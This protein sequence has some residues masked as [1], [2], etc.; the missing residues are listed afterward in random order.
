MRGGD[1]NS[2]NRRTLTVTL[3]LTV[4]LTV[5]MSVTV[6]GFTALQYD[7]GGRRKGKMEVAL[8]R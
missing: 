3:S 2:L 7:L 8:A 6:K 4:I 1:C 5:T